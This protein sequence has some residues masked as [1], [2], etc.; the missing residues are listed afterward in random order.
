MLNS[1]MGN[2]NMNS[3]INIPQSPNM[4]NSQMGNR[5]MNS[6]MN[7]AMNIPQSSNMLNSQME[8]RNM[9][10][11]INIPQSSNMLNSQMQKL[12]GLVNMPV[13]MEMP[14][15]INKTGVSMEML[16]APINNL[17]SIQTSQNMS[18]KN[19]A[20]NK[21]TTSQQNILRSNNFNMPEIKNINQPMQPKETVKNSVKNI[22]NNK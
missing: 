19:E 22:C 2:R 13:S 10:S 16:F 15:G 5:N 7:S 3:S 20:V 18:L 8:K 9:N 14:L 4:L 21:S 12:S 1:Q 17:S 6:A 11:S